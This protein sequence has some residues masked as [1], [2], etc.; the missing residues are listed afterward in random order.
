MTLSGAASIHI[1]Q[2]SLPSLPH[3]FCQSPY[4]Y[5]EPVM[6][7]SLSRW[8][9]LTVTLYAANFLL[10]LAWPNVVSSMIA[11][12]LYIVI[13][14]IIFACYPIEICCLS[15]FL[16]VHLS[17]LVSLNM[18]EFGGYMA[19]L[20][21]FGHASTATA[22]YT[23]YALIFLLISTITAHRIGTRWKWLPDEGMPSS[24]A[25]G[26]HPVF[27]LMLPLVW[28]GAVSYLAIRGLQTGFP[29][30]TGTD[31]LAF[32]RFDLDIVSLNLLLLKFV[33]GSAVGVGA[34]FANHLFA[35]VC[36]SGLFV[37][38]LFISFLYG[39]KFFVMIGYTL[40]FLMPFSI[41]RPSTIV[42]TLA[43]LAPVGIIVLTVS[44]IVT[45]FVYS[46]Y[47]RLKAGAT[48]ERLEDRVASQGAVWFAAVDSSPAWI[49]FDTAIISDNLASL[50][51]RSPGDYVFEHRLAA[52][53]FVERYYPQKLYRSSIHNGGSVTPTI[54]FEAY[55]LVIFGYLG[56][57]I[58]TLLAGLLVGIVVA[59]FHR[60][61][62][63]GDPFAVLLPAYL[64]TG[65][66][67][68]MIQ[69]T[70]FSIFSVSVLKAYAALLAVQLIVST[71]TRG[72]TP[73][74][75]R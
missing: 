41:R 37:A 52:F 47:G 54:I 71:A 10:A 16:I 1:N 61:M 31:R 56:L 32:R 64:M 30:I 70:L 5:R 2:A 45:L 17:A 65:C 13:V 39:D 59:Y 75:V 62:S 36:Y 48:L 4:E 74:P 73:S 14:L 8:V 11:T 40:F 43:R 67:Y 6:G 19:E 42:T 3:N 29:L 18:I 66:F 20:H 60:A 72:L 26:S 22:S 51:A 44:S 25:A 15:P 23:L 21:Q 28:L 69:A 68:L 46:E 33:I 24:A 38:Y 27:S 9:S 7:S 12:A 50:V 53:Y 57:V 35:K 58:E 63:R 49:D 34:A 55:G